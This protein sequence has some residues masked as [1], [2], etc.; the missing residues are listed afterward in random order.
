MHAGDCD[1]GSSSN[2]SDDD[3]AAIPEDQAPLVAEK[4]GRGRDRGRKRRKIKGKKKSAAERKCK[5]PK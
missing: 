4:E 1:I 5:I 2:E 3:N